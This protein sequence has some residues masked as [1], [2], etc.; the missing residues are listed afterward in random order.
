MQDQYADDIGD[1]VTTGLLRVISEG[2]CLG[3]AWYL[4]TDP[5]SINTGDGRH[6]KYLVTAIRRIVHLSVEIVRIVE[7]LPNALDAASS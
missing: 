6:I 3:V 5:G 4:C 1:F 2:K 7:A